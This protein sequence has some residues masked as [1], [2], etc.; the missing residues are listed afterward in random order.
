MNAQKW[1][2]RGANKVIVTSYLFPDAKFSMERLIELE[3]LVG[4]DR[5]VVDV[6]LFSSELCLM[7]AVDAETGNGSLR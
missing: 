4:K 5:L 6:R 3:N 7:E 1:I 2:E